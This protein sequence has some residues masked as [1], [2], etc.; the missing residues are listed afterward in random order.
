MLVEGDQLEGVRAAVEGAAASAVMPSVEHAEHQL[1]R[2]LLAAV[3]GRI[4]LWLRISKRNDQNE[5]MRNGWS[6]DDVGSAG[7]GC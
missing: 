7:E 2:L 3:D 4:W 5:V 6:C 1:T